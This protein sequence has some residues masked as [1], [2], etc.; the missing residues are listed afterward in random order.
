MRA[1]LQVD[2][3][4]KRSVSLILQHTPSYH[5]RDRYAVI[6]DNLRPFTHPYFYEYANLQ[7]ICLQ[8]LRYEGLKYAD[9]DDKA[10]GILFNGAWLW[11]EYLNTLLKKV[12]YLH[13]QNN[14]AKGGINI[15]AHKITGR[16]ISRYPDFV[17]DSE[18]DQRRVILDAKYKQMKDNSIGRDDMNQILSYLYLYRAGI[19]GFIAPSTQGNVG[20]NMGKL[21][22]YGGHIF[23]FKLGIPQNMADY[24]S[25]V[26]AIEANERGLLQTIERHCSMVGEAWSW[27]Q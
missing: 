16:N 27:N 13:P 25:F 17:R 18:D 4:T 2:S 5:V 10:H 6:N 11:E 24:G 22:G 21:N 14:S 26:E 1:I 7:N 12:G 9:N 19:G 23:K 20:L 3:D 15:F 8:I